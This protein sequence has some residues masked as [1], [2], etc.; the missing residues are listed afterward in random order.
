MDEERRQ[1]LADNL[2]QEKFKHTELR[3]A[4]AYLQAKPTPSPWNNMYPGTPSP[5]HREERAIPVVTRLM[6][7]EIILQD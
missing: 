6:V 5:S 2:N 1:E 7:T 3:K 4:L